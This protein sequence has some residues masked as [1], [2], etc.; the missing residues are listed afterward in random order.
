MKIFFSSPARFYDGVKQLSGY[1][2]LGEDKLHF[3]FDDFKHTH[4]NLNISLADIES[5]T[6]FPIF[7]I[8]NNGLK[9]SSKGEKID[10]FILKESKVFCEAIKNQIE[11][12]RRK[13]GL[14]FCD[15]NSL[16]PP[17]YSSPFCPC[18]QESIL[19]KLIC[20]LSFLII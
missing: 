6:V 14:F 13:L 2:E 16:N 7:N 12:L 9:V 3:H 10:L 17:I 5:V 18:L 11:R 15:K 8:A 20:D 4:L 19:K 1:L